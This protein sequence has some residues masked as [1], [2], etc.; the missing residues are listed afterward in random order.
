M[1]SVQLDQALA[2]RMIERG[3]AF[4]PKNACRRYP[5]GAECPAPGALRRLR[6]PELQPGAPGQRYLGQIDHTVRA[7]YAFEAEARQ[8]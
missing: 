4:A 8:K 1:T 5:A 3:V 2:D 6:P 7:V